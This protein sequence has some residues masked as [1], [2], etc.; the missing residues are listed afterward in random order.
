[1]NQKLCFFTLESDPAALDFTATYVSFCCAS[2]SF[3]M[4][5]STYSEV[6]VEAAYCLHYVYSLLISNE[7]NLDIIGECNEP[8]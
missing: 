6:V 2:C 3:Q 7:Q 4:A 8:S 1:M 5:H